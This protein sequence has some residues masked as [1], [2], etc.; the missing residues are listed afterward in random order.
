MKTQ[1][2]FKACF[3]LFLVC[4]S[5]SCGKGGGDVADTLI[6]DLSATFTNTTDAT[7]NY[8]FFNNTS[9][10]AISNFDGNEVI[11]GTLTNSFSGSYQN[12]KINFTFNSGPKNGTKYSGTI[13]GTAP[14]STITLTTPSGTITLQQHQ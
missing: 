1:I 13:K 4:L 8:F 9:G 11:N 7:D 5:F 12:S 6:P 10:V 14:T 3:C 2:F